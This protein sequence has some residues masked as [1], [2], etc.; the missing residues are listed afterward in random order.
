[1]IRGL[2]VASSFKSAEGGRGGIV[3]YIVMVDTIQYRGERCQAGGVPHEIW[4]R[5]KQRR[6]RG[7]EITEIPELLCNYTIGDV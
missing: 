1:M 7:K 5:G 4:K 2:L 3:T 6:W